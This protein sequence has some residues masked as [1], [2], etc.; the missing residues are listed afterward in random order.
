MTER[1]GVVAKLSLKAHP[2]AYDTRAL[3]AHLDP[4]T[5]PK[6]ERRASGS[7]PRTSTLRR[8]GG[9][10]GNVVVHQKGMDEQWGRGAEQRARHDLTPVEHIALDQSGD[11][12]DWQHQ[13]IRRSREH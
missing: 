10:A 11:D 8:T 13:L 4:Q 5:N 12:A 2:R 1:D 9:Q 6:S 3:Q 7:S